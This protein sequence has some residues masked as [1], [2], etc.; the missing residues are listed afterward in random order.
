[1]EHH[2]RKEMNDCDMTKQI[3]QENNLKYY[4]LKE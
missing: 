2:L 4:E 1:M 3:L